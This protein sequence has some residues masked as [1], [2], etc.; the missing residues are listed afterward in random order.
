MYRLLIY[1]LLGLIAVAMLLSAFGILTYNPLVI[2]ATTGYVTFI[3]WITNKQFAR[4][5][6]IPTNPESSL[7][8][9]LILAL[10]I[11]PTFD[12]HTF[13]FLTVVGV[14]A[15]A[16]KY[17]L[18]FRGK[19]IFNP[20]AI[21]VVL[22][23]LGAGDTASWWVGSM[24]LAPFVILGGVLL[25]RKI[26]RLEMV[27]VYFAAVIVSTGV[28]A[29]LNQSNLLTILQ[30]TLL[31][32]SALFLGFVM[33][34]EPL[35]SPATQTQQRRYAVLTGILFPP[36]IQLLGVYSTPE[37]TLLIGN[38]YSFIVSP[39]IKLNLRLSGTQRWG[40]Q[41]QDFLFATPAPVSY[42]PGQ[43][44]EF[45]LPHD[46][47]DER[48]SRR[49]FT[50]ASSPTETN[51]RLGIKF[52]GKGSTFKQTMLSMDQATPFVGAQ[53]GG[54]FVLERDPRRK[55]AFIAGGIGVTPFRSM[56]KY[57]LD[58][59]D[60]RSASLLYIEKSAG[61][62]AYT[63]V[64]EQARRSP[65]L[66]VTYLLT[67]QTEQLPAGA[68]AGRLDAQK[69]QSLLP[70]YHDRLFYISGSHLMVRDTKRLLLTMGITPDNIRED[71]F[72]GY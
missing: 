13:I 41:T 21:A 36:Q 16:S 62:L 29:L 60:P 72:P 67:Q 56:M 6:R 43:Y 50:L 58:T 32:S 53:L 49:Y 11:S 19:H 42:L 12:L 39:I 59:N 27:G 69:I 31:H 2:A 35:T 14:L 71:F 65:N 26:Q 23:S 37:L 61:E 68:V 63:D 5:L 9:G 4:L 55:L 40:V 34:T 3:C 7:I 25:A 64:F 20:A 48:G 38:I 46:Q 44:M 70:D 22:T 52:Y 47:P 24:W 18:T 17:L 8:T 45:T 54:D 57:L 15:M 30:T 1:Y 66:T 10:I 33:L 28:F 51:L